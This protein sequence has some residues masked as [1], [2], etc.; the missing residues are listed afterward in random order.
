MVTNPPPIDPALLWSLIKLASPLISTTTSQYERNKAKWDRRFASFFGLTVFS[1]CDIWEIVKRVFD[2]KRLTKRDFLW[3]LY[4]LKVYPTESQAAATFN[5]S[6]TTWR[7]TVK[8][9]VKILKEMDQIHLDDRWINWNI[10]A[11]SIYV[12]GVDVPVTESRPLD[13]ELFSHKFKRAGYRFQV[14]TAIGSSRIVHVSSGTPCGLF[15]DLSQVQRTLLCELELEEKVAAD[16]GYLGDERV[17][18]KL[19]GT[20]PEIKKHNKNWNLM[21][22]RH[23]TVNKRMKDFR[24]LAGLYRGRREEI[25]V[26][27]CAIAQITNIISG[28]VPRYTGIG[29]AFSRI[30][31]EQGVV[32]FWRGNFTNCIRYFPTQAINLA[33]KDFFKSMFPKYSPKSEFWSF[34]AANMASGGAAG[35]FSLSFVYP[36]DYARTRL[37]SDVGSGKRQFNGLWDCLVKTAKG[38]KGIFGLYQGFGISVAGIIPYRGVQF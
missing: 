1:A 7:T 11:P 31:A 37:A 25:V 20:S 8:R 32:S 34:F 29:N 14:A 19:K 10:L 35:A 38:P 4:F 27:F 30:A 36:L 15:N 12:D 21:G 13:R 33:S 17:L 2:N 23:E 16:R 3:G 26:I 28:E 9:V 6:E 22:A 5:T 24:I 18:T